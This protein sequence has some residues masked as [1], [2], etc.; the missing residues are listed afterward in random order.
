[1]PVAYTFSPIVRFIPTAKGNVIAWPDTSLY[2][3]TRHYMTWH[4]WQ[5]F[6]GMSYA[7]KFASHKKVCK[8]EVQPQPNLSFIKI[9][10]AL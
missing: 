5:T 10:H 8:P 3:L 9:V 6:V 2:D 7:T 1:M 4:W